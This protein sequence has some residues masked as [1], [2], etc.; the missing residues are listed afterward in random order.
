MTAFSQHRDEGGAQPSSEQPSSEKTRR[1]YDLW[2][3]VYDRV[4]RGYVRA[5]TEALLAEARPVRGEAVL[6]VGCGTGGFAV[7]LLAEQPTAQPTERAPQAVPRP[8]TGVD[9][10]AQMLAA[11]REKTRGETTDTHFVK[12]DAHDLPFDD[13]TFDVVVSASVL[14]Y[15]A[16]PVAALGEMQRVARPSGR[17]VVL[18]WCRDFRAMRWMDALLRRVDPAHR[19]V[20]TTVEL[21]G[22]L[23]EA[24]LAPT[25]TR[26]FRHWWWGLMVATSQVE[27]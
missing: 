19:R 17:V 24:G 16:D 18:D 14:H 9:L 3:A 10:S 11:A 22:L 2:A 15:L 25:R 8:I 4:W 5:T 26:R 12:A 27:G 20:F 7:R 13:A 21:R 1:Q 23:R 6:D